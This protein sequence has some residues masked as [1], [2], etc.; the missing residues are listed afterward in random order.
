LPVTADRTITHGEQTISGALAL[1]MHLLFLALLVFGVSWQKREPVALV[2]DL[3]S[4]LPPLPAPRAEPPPQVKPA[5]PKPAPRAEAKPAP[6]PEPRPQPKADIDLR[7]KK[8]RELKAKE[9]ALAEKK[10]KEELALAEKKKR[11]EQAQLAALKKQQA[12]EAEVKRA[13]QEQAD[14]LKKLAEQQA[15]AQAKEVD[16]YK[17]LIADKIRS[18]II[19]PPGLQGNPQVELDVTVLPGGEVLEVKPRKGSGQPSWDSAVERAVLKAQPLPLPQDP[20][21]HSRFR[22]LNLRFRPKE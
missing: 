18:R 12:Q 21:L 22:E 11:E 2:A 17:Q 3:W 20:T 15:A 10:R 14:A 9:K 19:E 16:K 13:A 6:K 1:L 7:E 5:P 8:E 4:N